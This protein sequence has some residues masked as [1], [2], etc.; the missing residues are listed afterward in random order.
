MPEE[1]KRDLSENSKITIQDVANALGISKTTVS[2][3]ISGKGRIGES[4]RKMVMEYIEEHG[5]KPNPIA[6]GLAQHRTYNIGWAMPGDSR[7]TELPFFQRCMVGLSEEA[8]EHDYDVLLSLVYDYSTA[9]LER[10]VNGNKVDGIIL[11]RTLVDD[12]N[13]RFLKKAGIPFVVIG[14]SEEKNVIQI[15]NDHVSACK[16]LTSIL[17][18]KGMRKLV[19]IGGNEN[20]V[21]NQNRA[22][23]FNLAIADYKESGI[24][25]NVCMNTRNEAD[26]VKIV[27]ESLAKDVDC[28]VCADDRI[29]AAVLSVLKE[30]NVNVPE[31]VKV[32]SFYNSE[33][34]AN[35][36]ISVTALQYDPKELGS[37]A[38]RILVECIE[39]ESVPFKTLMSYEVL[40]RDS[41]K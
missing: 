37:T 21:V 28:F 17:I 39:G 23:G 36:D 7:I 35:S 32:A 13:V 4:T 31:D 18:M 24:N 26:V 22:K 6:K 33:L 41:T 38:C 30:D 12:E 11:G 1:Y 10:M 9:G 25:A 2:R 3:A 19:L 29:C 40:L 27:R 15:D 8:A 34:I 16:E 5:Y 20:H 14:S